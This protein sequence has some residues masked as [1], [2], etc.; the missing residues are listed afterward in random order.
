VDDFQASITGK[1]I[2]VVTDGL[3][4]RYSADFDSPRLDPG[5]AIIEFLVGIARPVDPRGH[6]QMTAIPFVFIRNQSFPLA[7][8]EAGGATTAGLN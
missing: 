2:R 8:L 4:T 7:T 3:P 6:Q 5:D 1:F